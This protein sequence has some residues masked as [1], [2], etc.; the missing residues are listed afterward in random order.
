MKQSR[1]KVR[2]RG[3][4]FELPRRIRRLDQAVEFPSDIA[5]AHQWLKR[6]TGDV[7]EF[8]FE[9]YEIIP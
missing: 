4:V 5:R 8:M 1:I 2:I 9:Q 3:L 7:D 6:Q